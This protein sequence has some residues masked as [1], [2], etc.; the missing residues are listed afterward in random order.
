MKTLILALSLLS[1]NALA[2]GSDRGGGNAI[3]CF[4][5]ASIP[6][7]IRTK[8]SPDFGVITS[9]ALGRIT[10]IEML[11]LYQA[12]LPKRDSLYPARIAKPEPGETP[13]AMAERLLDRIS[14]YAPWV[15]K[16]I[17][18]GQSALRGNVS[19]SKDGVAT[20]DDINLLFSYDREHCVIA[21]MA[22]QDATNDEL[23]VDS[24]LFKHPKHSI[25]SR[26]A[27]Y[28][29]EWTYYSL[30]RK[31]VTTSAGVRG[32]VGRMM[33]ASGG[34]RVSALT[35]AAAKAGLIMHEYEKYNGIQQQ[36]SNN[37][38]NMRQVIRD[39]TGHNWCLD[40]GCEDG[41]RNTFWGFFQ[42][43]ARDLNRFQNNLCS[44]LDLCEE[45]LKEIVAK[46]TDPARIQEGERLIRTTHQYLEKIQLGKEIET[47][48]K[49]EFGENAPGHSSSGFPLPSDDR[50]KT[51][52]K[53]DWIL[54]QV[55][56]QVDRDVLH[57]ATVQ[58]FQGEFR[59]FNES[60]GKVRD[61]ALSE[62]ETLRGSPMQELDFLELPVIN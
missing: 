32:I 55:K 28:L 56:A 40:G 52:G 24:R 54:E 14:N 21:T 36:L 29:H 45:A 44:R 41:Q 16:K 53:Y 50:E 20:I 27:M 58:A 51:K 31:G 11:D 3:V 17:E 23:F 10:N 38:M 35:N 15:H 18:I 59:N 26:A 12:K 22:A 8:G 6:K 13:E 2:G 4:D 46:E 33:I 7:A 19:Q 61:R 42:S 25:E 57:V 60:M 34:E 47:W 49:A 43:Y 30:L 37:L 5:S 1:L 39:L 48:S 62:I 9:K